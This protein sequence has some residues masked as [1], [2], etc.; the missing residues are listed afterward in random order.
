MV[1]F[2]LRFAQGHILIM[3]RYPLLNKLS[4]PTYSLLLV[5]KWVNHTFSH[6]RVLICSHWQKGV[7][8]LF[9]QVHLWIGTTVAGGDRVSINTT[10]T[11]ARHDTLSDCV[12]VVFIAPS[13]G[14]FL[15]FSP[16]YFPGRDVTFQQLFFS[17]TTPPQ[18]HRYTDGRGRWGCSVSMACSPWTGH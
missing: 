17:H 9:S 14:G 5:R 10:F 3:S 4:K 1:C 7:Y 13:T 11:G 2:L 15:I 18:E 6:S 16:L 8:G 12:L